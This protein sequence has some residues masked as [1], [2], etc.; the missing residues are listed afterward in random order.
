MAPSFPT[1]WKIVARDEVSST[2]EVCK[3]LLSEGQIVAVV[4]DSQ[5]GGKGRRGNR[6]E[7]PRGGLY[8]TIGFSVPRPALPGL[9]SGLSLMVGIAIIEGL[10]LNAHDVGLKWPN[11]LVHSV[12]RRKVG[13]V[14]I[15]LSEIHRIANILSASALIA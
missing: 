14:L 8:T 7:S 4:A 3:E 10:G 11:D 15:E 5:T 12:S 2:M 6:W 1:A 13:G 9:W